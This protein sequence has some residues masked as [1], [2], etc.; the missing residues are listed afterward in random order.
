LRRAGID[1]LPKVAGVCLCLVKSPAV[2]RC[3]ASEKGG[4]AQFAS[5]LIGQR[6][7]VH[8]SRSRTRVPGQ[9]SSSTTTSERRSTEYAVM[10]SEIERL[11]NLE[12]FLKFASIPD[13]MYVT[14]DYASYPVVWE[15]QSEGRC[16]APEVYR[17][18]EVVLTSMSFRAISSIR[19]PGRNCHG[20]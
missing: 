14:L 18:F 3:S 17:Q 12:G 10:P 6:E 20:G 1:A 11:P 19:L 4:T 2:D 5:R 8:L 13:W 7:V 15:K 16:L 9:W